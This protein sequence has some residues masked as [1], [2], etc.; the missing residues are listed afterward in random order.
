MSHGTKT[1][2]KVAVRIRPRK[3]DELDSVLQIMDNTIMVKNKKQRFTYDKVYTDDSTQEDIFDIGKQVVQ[4]AINGYNSC[5]FAYGLTGCFARGTKIMRYDNNTIKYINVE[6]VQINDE[7][8][9]DDSTKRTVLKLFR[10]K[11]MMYRICAPIGYTNIVVNADH[12]L[13][14]WVDNQYKEIKVSD[15]VKNKYTYPCIITK[16]EFNK[17][18]PSSIAYLMGFTNQF[19]DI[20]YSSSTRYTIL[21]GILDNKG[22]TY[23]D[24]IILPIQKKYI[25]LCRSLGLKVIPHTTYISVYGELT[26]IPTK[27]FTNLVD[28][29]VSKFRINIEKLHVDDYY[30]FMLDGNHRFIGEGYTILRNSG[31]TYTMMGEMDKDANI[32]NPGLIP[33]ICEKLFIPNY[34]VELSYL[35]IYAEHIYDLLD[36]NNKNL[37]VRQHPVYGPYV[38][39]CTTML[40]NDYATIRKMIHKGNRLRHIASTKM[41]NRSSRSHTILTIFFT[42]IEE[43]N[44]V[45]KEIV[46]KINLIDLAGSERV[47]VSKVTGINLKEAIQINKSLSSLGLVIS[48]L[49]RKDK[50]IPFRDSILT[51]LLKESLSGN[52]KTYMIATCCDSSKYLNET[53]NTL[54]YAYSAKQIELVVKVNE[55]PNDK[56]IREL[57]NE[58]KVLKEKLQQKRLSGISTNTPEVKKLKDEIEQRKKLMVEKEK[59]WVKKLEESNLLLIGQTKT[60]E[61]TKKE[62]EES[63]K[64]ITRLKSTSTAISLQEYYDNKIKELQNSM[65]SIVQYEELKKENS[66]L[67]TQLNELRKENKRLEN[68][69]KTERLIHNKKVRQLMSKI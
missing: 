57:K 62:L 40:V 69:I 67:H 41:N 16:V 18:L 35:E 25:S 64:E 68:L 4:N 61:E 27:L 22:I 56:I 58:I 14:C 45:L 33:R 32:K 50:H 65:V 52:S 36:E 47:E 3:K 34:K 6:D 30:G 17:V 54:R 38:E 53:L 46:S 39:N 1:S 11:Q 8:M 5:V 59:S 55:D 26:K 66:K 10:G 31:K 48:K 12:Y 51:W 20:C 44:G 21:A 9:G 43:T 63:K 24:H 42:K 13:V 49:A 7:I 23:L 15:Y 2:V 37:K 19:T 29:D 28:T 60:I